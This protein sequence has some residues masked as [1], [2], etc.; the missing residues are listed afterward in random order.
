MPEI[1]IWLGSQTYSHLSGHCH[2]SFKKQLNMMSSSL[3]HISQII[4]PGARHKYSSLI[5]VD[6]IPEKQEYRLK[7]IRHG[8]T[9]LQ[10]TRKIIGMLFTAFMIS[11]VDI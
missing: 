5:L 10:Y 2:R 8:K 9:D 7:E 3:I 1:D 11:L 6:V 4:N